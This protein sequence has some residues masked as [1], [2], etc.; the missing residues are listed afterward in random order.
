ML[1]EHRLRRWLVQDMQ[2]RPMPWV[3]A[4]L[5]LPALSGIRSHLTDKEPV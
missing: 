5:L 1:E 2:V 3:D 4:Y